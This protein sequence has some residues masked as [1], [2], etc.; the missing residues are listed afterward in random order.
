[1]MNGRTHIIKRDAL[2]DMKSLMVILES[3]I[4]SIEKDT[5]QITGPDP[6][7]T[8]VAAAKVARQFYN[9]TP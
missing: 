5:C 7:A 2:N 3:S 9:E 6:C 4:D 1:M 8:C